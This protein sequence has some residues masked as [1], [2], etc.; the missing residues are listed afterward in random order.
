[1]RLDASWPGKVA[2]TWSVTCLLPAGAGLVSST[3]LDRLRRKADS[4]W[5]VAPRAEGDD[6]EGRAERGVGA[7]APRA[8]DD[9]RAEDP[10]C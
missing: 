9:D 8:G 6:P 3:D 4:T 2:H 5:S 7:V 10:S 1:M